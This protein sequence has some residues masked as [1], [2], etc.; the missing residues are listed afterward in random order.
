MYTRK[1]TAEEIVDAATAQRAGKGMQVLTTKT[2]DTSVKNPDEMVDEVP[3]L[4]VSVK[5]TVAPKSQTE[6]RVAKM[7]KVLQA[8]DDTAT[9]HQ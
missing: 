8:M 2:Q 1:R 6:E 7:P 4:Q 5:A 9:K 3:Q